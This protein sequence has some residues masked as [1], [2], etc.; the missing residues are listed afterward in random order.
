[1]AKL[2][3]RAQRNRQDVVVDRGELGEQTHHHG[4]LIWGERRKQALLE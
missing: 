1:M 4:P 2:L 3:R